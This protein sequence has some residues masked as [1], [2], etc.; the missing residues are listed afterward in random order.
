ML[1][2]SLSIAKK[3][4]LIAF[5][6]A[7]SGPTLAQTLNYR[8]F[9]YQGNVSEPFVAQQN[10]GN[11]SARGWYSMF[12]GDTVGAGC[13]PHRLQNGPVKEATGLFNF[14]TDTGISQGS[15]GANFTPS[16]NSASCTNKTK[17][18][19]MHSHYKNFSN[20]DSPAGIGI[21]TTAGP[22]LWNVNELGFFQPP[23]SGL[24]NVQGNFLGYRCGNSC[25]V[26][27][28][29]PKNVFPFSGNSTDFNQLRFSLISDQTLRWLHAEDPAQQQIKQQML[30]TMLSLG[31][32]SAVQYLFYTAFKGV[33]PPNG[34]D[35]N[36]DPIQ[37]GMSYIIGPLGNAG[38]STNYVA[39]DGSVHSMFTSWS[40]S[41][42]YDSTWVG[43]RP[44]EAEITFAQFINGLKLSTAH[45]LK[46]SPNLVTRAEI[47]SRFGQNFDKPMN[48][49]VM[50][51]EVAHENY[52]PVW[53]T[54]RT[55]IGGG[56]T[57]LKVLSF[58]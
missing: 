4:G 14:L 20:A 11:P 13:S 47:E 19:Q 22:L 31:N 33:Y 36:E 42:V 30:I 55:A 21:F 23:D 53:N 48:W 46:K 29:D 45:F 32:N 37:G 17:W 10:P 9:I 38:Q 16:S 49:V 34:A 1:R 24:P 6:I 18:G 41:T 44:F 54:S 5:S 40:G 26:G 2:I 35:V 57:S 12:W 28:A 27:A 52:N 43:T 7:A 51:V 25:Y 56:F 39:S 58:P 15:V 50:A 3:I 8:N